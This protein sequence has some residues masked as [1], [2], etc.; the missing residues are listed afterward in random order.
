[1]TD[2]ALGIL[3]TL[4]MN[5]LFYSFLKGCFRK[6][7]TASKDVLVIIAFVVLNSLSAILLAE[8]MP[9]KMIFSIVLLIMFAIIVF[10]ISIKKSILVSFVFIGLYISAEMIVYLFLQK[11]DVDNRLSDMTNQ[12]GGFI[13]ELASQLIV[14]IIVLVLTILL[15][16]SNLSRMD[17]KGW[18]I[19]T[20]LPLF[21]LIMVVIFIYSAE[22]QILG[23]LFYALLFLVSGLLI[24]NIM[25]LLLLDNVISREIETQRKELLIEQ[26]DHLNRMYIS[27]SEER[28][29]QKSRSHDYLNHLNTMLSLAK[30]GKKDEEIRYLE[31]QIGRELKSV[32]VINTGNPIINA[33]LN[34]KYTEAK[35]QGIMIPIVADNLEGMSISDSDLVTIMTNI[36]DNAIEA[37][38][39]RHDKKIIF[40]IVRDDD[41][42]RIYSCNSVAENKNRKDSLFTTKKDADQHG[43]GIANIKKAVN[44]NNGECFIDIRDHLFQ[45]S[46]TIPLR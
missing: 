28:E 24:L 5:L 45:I 11:I 26:A 6:D 12:S 20:L 40:K 23:D 21:T 39:D 44:D 16:R 38:Q 22:K 10:G 31:E 30:S 27:L 42:L 15:K 14:L 18:L 29:K 34:V 37:V 41:V 1:M 13:A 33:V 2:I 36:L 46:I 9:V 35:E 32:D 4:T 43:Y 8:I 7:R 17:Y 25:Q 3:V 19:F